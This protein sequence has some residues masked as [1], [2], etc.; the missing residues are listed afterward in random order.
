V[1]GQGVVVEGVEGGNKAPTQAEI[2]KNGAK[3]GQFP[4]LFDLKITETQKYFIPRCTSL[5]K[6]RKLLYLC[7]TIT[8][9]KASLS[10]I[11]EIGLRDRLR[12]CERPEY[13][14]V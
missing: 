6:L 7:G 4:A 8:S 1:P 2:H 9:S 12:P 13:G 5:Q 14:K 11:F 10:Q 3:N